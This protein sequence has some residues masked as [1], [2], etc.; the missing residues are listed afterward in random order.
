MRLGGAGADGAVAGAQVDDDADQ[1][2]R[3]GVCSP[4]G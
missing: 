3:F 1:D 4:F 2:W